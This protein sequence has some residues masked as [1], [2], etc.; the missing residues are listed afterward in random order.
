M[1]RSVPT[2]PAE[3]GPFLLNPITPECILL[4]HATKNLSVGVVQLDE[5]G[6]SRV[7]SDMVG[8]SRGTSF[9]FKLLAPGSKLSKLVKVNVSLFF[10]RH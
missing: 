5:L 1:F 3:S 9:F 7:Q 8:Y 2:A 4:Y 6:Y 10:K